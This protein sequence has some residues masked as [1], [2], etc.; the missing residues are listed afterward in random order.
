MHHR[1]PRDSE[2][3]RFARATFGPRGTLKL[4]R[5]AVGLDLLRAPVNVALAPVFLVSRLLA[6]LLLLVRMRRPARWIL[7]RPVFFRTA[8]AA[9]VAEG[10]HAL[11]ARL[12][13]LGVGVAAGPEAR[14]RGIDD[15][16]GVRSAVSEI[17]TS[18]IVLAV[19]FAIF[20]SATP[21]VVSL[22]PNVAERLAQAEAARGFWAGETLGR[23]WYGTFPA[24]IPAHRI[25]LTGVALA[26]AASVV[27][28]FAG[29]IADP[30]QLALGTHRRRL[31]RLMRRL[32]CGGEA[33]LAAEHVAARTSDLVDAAM[34]VLR[35]FR[36]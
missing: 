16:V 10:L 4:H 18:L 14:A 19:G 26:M 9:R 12:D 21:G 34:A 5:A 30:V 22:A 15:Y 32:D 8:V 33:P 36:G 2:I 24:T 13:E 31:N 1:D 7:A 28:T 11:L 20:H 35:V 25:V 17:T 3:R 27:T 6:L 29:L 23:A